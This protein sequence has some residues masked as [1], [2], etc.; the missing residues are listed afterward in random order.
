MTHIYHS[1]IDARH[2]LTHLNPCRCVLPSNP[3]AIS[4]ASASLTFVPSR[5]QHR[6]PNKFTQI[7]IQNKMSAPQRDSFSDSKKD[8]A[9]P[10]PTPNEPLSRS[11]RIP[12]NDKRSNSLHAHPN[13]HSTHLPP[14]CKSG[15]VFPQQLA[16]FLDRSTI[17]PL[18]FHLG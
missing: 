7:H 6:Q 2:P 5:L 10:E 17:I 16:P 15:A 14:M 4:R 1:F 12:Q 18:V 8:R 13:H 11:R 3:C 9:K